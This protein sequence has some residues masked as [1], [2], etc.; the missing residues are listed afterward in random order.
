M[1][2]TVQTLR[3]VTCSIFNCFIKHSVIFDLLISPG[4][5][6]FD[7]KSVNFCFFIGK[8]VA[9]YAEAKGGGL[10]ELLLLSSSW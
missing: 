3:L 2:V 6:T 10:L 7:L 4:K 9:V 1:D 8:L 5:G